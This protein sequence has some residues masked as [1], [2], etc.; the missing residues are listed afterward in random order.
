MH[1]YMY[2]YVYVYVCMYLC[3]CMPKISAGG[4]MFIGGGKGT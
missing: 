3:V 1:I 4:Q 2:V